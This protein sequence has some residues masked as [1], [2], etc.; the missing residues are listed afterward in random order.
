MAN[1][2]DTPELDPIPILETLADH[3]VD[4]VAIGSYAA[5]LQDVPL[6]MTDIDIVP[7]DDADNRRRL[8]AALEDL[9][10]HEQVGT[11]REPIDDLLE[12]PDSL[13]HSKFR[14]FVT[15]HGGVDVVNHPDGFERGYSDLI[16]NSHEAT[17][18]SADNPNRTVTVTVADVSDIAESKR[19]AGRAKDI[20]ALPAFGSVLSPREQK[21]RLRERYRRE[22][23]STEAPSGDS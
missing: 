7:R 22:V 9:G 20:T 15:D 8:V 19:R 21:R 1:A 17:V 16:E 6:P 18:R 10:A 14:T 23:E 4:F 12:N 3:G 2:H 13:A 11:V 5:I